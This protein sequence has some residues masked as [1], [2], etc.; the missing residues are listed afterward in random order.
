MRE[1]A[2]EGDEPNEAGQVTD[3]EFPCRA[4]RRECPDINFA[5]FCI[6][7]RHDFAWDSDKAVSMRQGDLWPGAGGLTLKSFVVSTAKD[8]P[9][10]KR[11][12]SGGSLLRP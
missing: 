2:R 8:T 11:A 4:A 1:S 12:R 10:Q 6:H 3:V 5:L 9:L 7:L